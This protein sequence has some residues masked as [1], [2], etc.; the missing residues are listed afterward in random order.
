MPIEVQRPQTEPWRK[1]T[2]GQNTRTLNL[3]EEGKA[4]SSCWR[5]RSEIDSDELCV[6]GNFATHDPPSTTESMNL[7]K[8]TQTSCTIAVV[9]S[10]DPLEDETEPSASLSQ[11][12]RRAILL[13]GTHH[14]GL[15][16]TLHPL[17]HREQIAHVHCAQ[18]AIVTALVSS[19]RA[20]GLPRRKCADVDG[21]ALAQ[22]RRREQRFHLELVGHGRARLVVLAAEV[23]G[24]W[25]VEV[26]AFVSR[27]CRVSEFLSPC[28]SKKNCQASQGSFSLLA[29]PPPPNASRR[30]RKRKFFE[31]VPKVLRTRFASVSQDVSQGVG[32]AGVSHAFRKGS[33]KG[34]AMS[35][36]N[37]SQ[38]SR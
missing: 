29:P 9:E 21:A 37:V 38:E 2:N 27:L 5:R 35:L 26:R 16:R 19:I 20:D 32:L 22:A 17:P 18:L 12:S 25:S 1:P 30:V 4:R 28:A 24:R 10:N 8:K 6:D 7:I 33:P 36:A 13:N 31:G 14:G 23:G 11:I 15:W 3:L 34:L